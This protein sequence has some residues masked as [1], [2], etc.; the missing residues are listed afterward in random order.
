MIKSKAILK[1]DENIGAYILDKPIYDSDDMIEIYIYINDDL[2]YFCEEKSNKL[3]DSYSHDIGLDE[4][5]IYEVY[6][7]NILFSYYFYCRKCINNGNIPI[8][9]DKNDYYWL[10]YTS[11]IDKDYNT[12]FHEIS[13]DWQW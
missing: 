4:I 10:E 13:N 8:L 2:I 11:D 7:K 12:D 6:W 5:E 3:P 1:F 9:I